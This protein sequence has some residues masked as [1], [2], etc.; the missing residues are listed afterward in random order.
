MVIR[1]MTCSM[2]R[3]Y[4]RFV[5]ISISIH[6]SSNIIKGTKLCIIYYKIMCFLL[7]RLDVCYNIYIMMK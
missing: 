2:D 6:D 1:N 3:I 4:V 7:V 5:P